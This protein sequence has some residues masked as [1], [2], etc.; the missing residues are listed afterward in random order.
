MAEKSKNF[1][2]STSPARDASLLG[3][4]IHASGQRFEERLN[5]AFAYYRRAGLASIE[6]TPEPMRPVKNLGSGKFIAFFEKKAQPDYSGVL[7]GGQAAAFEAKYTS[8][9]RMEQKR[10]TEGQARFLQERYVLGAGCWV[11]AGFSSGRV[12]RVPWPV[13]RDMK[14]HFGRASVKEAELAG[15]AVPVRGGVPLVLEGLV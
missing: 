9:S 7:R 14:S 5:M 6:K 13:W 4:Q 2:G 12:Y 8:G 3:A 11:L 15:H 10:V 1:S